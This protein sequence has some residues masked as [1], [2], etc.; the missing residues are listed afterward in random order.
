[1]RQVEKAYANVGGVIK[2][3]DVYANIGG[4]VKPIK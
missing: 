1:M 3:C 4:T 2:E